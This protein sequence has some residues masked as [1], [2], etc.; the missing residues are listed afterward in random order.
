MW[1]TARWSLITVAGLFACADGAGPLEP[2]GTELLTP[3]FTAGASVC[4]TVRF[5]LVA[6][7]AGGFFQGQITGD[8]EGTATIVFDPDS[9]SFTGVTTHSGG[10]AQ[11]AITGG[12]VP[13]VTG[14]ETTFE[15]LAHSVDRPGSPPTVSEVS[16]K[17]RALSGV[18]R[19]NLA[20]NGEFNVIP[21]PHADLDYHGVICP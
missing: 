2:D 11:W 18:Q 9:F 8:L 16:G 19:A 15:N 14:F 20:Y 3:S 12:V 6:V 10:N 5:N 21:F 17:H 7:P 1:R 4:Y 13:G